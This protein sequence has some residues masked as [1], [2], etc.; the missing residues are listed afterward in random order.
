[1]R[2]TMRPEPRRLVLTHYPFSIEIATR[3]GDLDSLGH[4]N[5]VSFGRLFEEARVRFSLHIR[6]KKTLDELHDQARLVLVSNNFSY[7]REAQYPAPVTIGVG[8]TRIGTTSYSVGCAM[9][10][11]GHCVATNDATLVH[12]DR[13][14]SFPLPAEICRILAENYVR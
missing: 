10:Q 14:T 9:F 2:Q 12:A 11:E 8:V 5:N 4:I 7:L 13:G 3:Y 1:M 6:E